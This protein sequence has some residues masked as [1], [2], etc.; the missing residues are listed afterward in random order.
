MFPLFEPL[1]VGAMEVPNRMFMAPL[2]RCRAEAGH[3][4]GALMA[5]YYAQRAT[6]GMI[7]AEATMA[8]EGNSAF[9]SEPGIYNEAQV[10]GWKGVTEAVH[11]AGGRIFLQI[12]HGGR[13][14]HPLLNNGAQ[15]VAP[16]AIPIT[17]DEANTLEG[18][19]P[20]AV[21]R[22]L[23]DAEIPG[24][25]AGFKKAAENAKSAGFDGVEVHGA[26]GYLLDEFLRDGAN[27][28]TGPYG[29]PIQNRARLLLE[30]IDSAA[31]VWGA[32]RVGVRTS[33]LNSYNSMS[34]SDPIGLVTWL[35]EKLSG[36]GLA[37]WHVMR[38]DFLG[39]QSGDV[40]TAARAAYRGVL[41]GNM[42]YSPQEAADAIAAKKLDAVA[43]GTPFL[44]NPDLPARVQA[45][46]E[47][48]T[49]DPATFY[50]PGAKG[51]TDYPAMNTG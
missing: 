13:A 28:R 49:P 40:M 51:Y 16:S 6:A 38:A 9:I 22:E 26:N 2:T 35:G 1:R 44:A 42:G 47:L 25:V 11:G 32:D 39:E 20:Y 48:N 19:K 10:A 50:T 29:G 14:C 45:G 37:Y 17:N 41:V 36:L 31:G 24:V 3:V 8:M 30:V 34:D 27:K 46:T 33:P 43:F 23:S 15:P 18:K 5:Q 7:I 12:W 21:P 4:P